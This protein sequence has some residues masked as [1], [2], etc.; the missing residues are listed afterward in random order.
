VIPLGN[1]TW[2]LA[3]ALLAIVTV[4]VVFWPLPDPPPPPEPGPIAAEEEDPAPEF[5]EESMLTY[6]VQEGDTAEGIARLFV[7]PLDDFLS[8]NRIPLGGDV[9]PGQRMWIP[10]ASAD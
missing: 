8:V 6:T 10:P 2:K 3:L 7:V 5:A 1:W 9:E 4:F